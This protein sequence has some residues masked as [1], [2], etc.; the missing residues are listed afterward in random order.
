MQKP[1]LS[2]GFMYCALILF[3]KVNIDGPGGLYC[4]DSVLVDELL[5]SFSVHHYDGKVIKAL[6]HTFELIPVYQEDSDWQ[7]FLTHLIKKSILQVEYRFGQVW[8]PYL[9]MVGLILLHFPPVCKNC[10]NLCLGT[11]KVSGL[12]PL[13]S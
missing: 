2:A 6:D 5:A 8:P 9:S 13:N 10:Q 4:G 7:I 11:V 12:N 1:A 3:V